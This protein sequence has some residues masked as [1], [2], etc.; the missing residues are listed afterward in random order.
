MDLRNFYRRM[1]QIE[2]DISEPFVVVV[3]EETADGGRAGVES[4]VPREL[5]ARLICEGRARLATPDETRM[6]HD[7]IAAA[8]REAEQAR[9]AERL[10]LSV[11][12]R[13][14]WLS[15]KAAQKGK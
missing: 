12:P 5:A 6:F 8:R 4:Q 13:E 7:R 14:D 2:A 1:R 10:Q 3:S 9:A 11:V 15:F